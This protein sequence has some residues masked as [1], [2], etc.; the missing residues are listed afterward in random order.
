MGEKPAPNY[1]IDRIDNNKGYSPENCRW[2]PLDKQSGNRRNNRLITHNGITRTL[3][4]WSRHTGIS[5]ATIRARID[6]HNW[7]IKDA[8]EKPVN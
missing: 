1:S 7:S 6:R 8:L 4:E 2:I 5:D 3:A